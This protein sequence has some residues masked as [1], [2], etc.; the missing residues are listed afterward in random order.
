MQFGPYSVELSNREKTFFPGAAITKGDLIDY[1]HDIAQT[2][3]PYMKDRP[4]T[5]HRFPDGIEGENWYQKN[6]GEYFPDWITTVTVDK[7]N[8][9]VTHVLCNNTATLVYLAN[10][11]CITL[12][13]WLSRVDQQHTPDRLIFDLDPPGDDFE[14]VRK[15]ALAVRELVEEL[16]LKPFVMTTGSSGCHVVSPIRREHNFDEVRDF[17]ESVAQL[18]AHRQPNQ[19]TTE[20]RKAKRHGRLYL[21]VGRNAYAQTGVSPYSVRAR[22]GAPV[23]TPLEWDELK[24]PD[25][26]P[27]SY[28]IENIGGRLGHI[29]DPWKNIRRH[30]R[31]LDR[32]MERLQDL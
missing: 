22:P 15:G 1:H 25:L 26:G 13:V 6:A 7:E 28:T 23:A 14:P 24:D 29:G 31:S 30:A 5:M 20:V 19:L 10:Q 16:G 11:A 21:D 12:H 2:M 9:V 32:P 3:L 17:A 8:G 18:L 4:L 27:R